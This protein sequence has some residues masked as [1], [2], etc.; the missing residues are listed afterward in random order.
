[1]L[2]ILRVWE[3]SHW[4]RLEILHILP[5]QM[6][7]ELLRQSSLG[8]SIYYAQ[9]FIM[10]KYVLYPI[11]IPKYLSYPLIMPKYLLYPI[12]MPKYL[13]YPIYYTEFIIPK[14]LLYPK[15][16]LRA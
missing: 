6:P 2:L 5:P 16:T 12:S 13:L 7:R 3:Y 4:I 10:P 1:M 8:P 9:V 15:I 14:Y 11:I